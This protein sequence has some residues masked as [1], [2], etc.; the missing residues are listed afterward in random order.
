MKILA[1]DTS[2]AYPSVAVL[3]DGGLL[4]EI[5][6]NIGLFH[7]SHLLPTVDYLLRLLSLAKEDINLIAATIGPGSF[8]GIRVGLSAA[9]ALC[10]SLKIPFAPVISLDALGLKEMGKTAVGIDAKKGEVFAAVYLNGKRETQPASLSVEE[11]ASLPVEVF[12]GDGALRFRELIKSKNPGAKISRRSLFSAAEVGLLGFEL[13]KRDQVIE[14]PRK[15]YP[16]YLRASDAE[17]K[18]WGK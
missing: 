4:G 6:L 3:E 5:N 11:F 9:K 1:W 12:I 2:T 17:I 15:I 14:D 7:S 10:F 13:W 18:K 8:T 16:L